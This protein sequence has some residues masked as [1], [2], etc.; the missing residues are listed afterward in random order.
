[1]SNDI[2]PAVRFDIFKRDNF[3]CQYCGLKPPQVVLHVDHIN[4][5]SKG[6]SDTEE[7]LITSCQSCNL[8]K[9][10]KPLER[11]KVPELPSLQDEAQKLEQLKQYQAHLMEKE[12]FYTAQA[13]TLMEFWA[14]MEGQKF[15]NGEYTVP[16][17]LGATVRS[18]LRKLS[19]ADIM[20]AMSIANSRMPGKSDQQKLRYFAGV[21]WRKIQEK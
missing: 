11:I 7:N 12:K 13:K 6:G 10:S 19:P 2:R 1:M 9:G 4:P 3:T 20:E 21:C 5:K 17:G 8:G 14:E 18:F 15:P 16:I